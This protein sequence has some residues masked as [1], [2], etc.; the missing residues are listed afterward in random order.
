M[1]LMH[2]NIF[3]IG[4]FNNVFLLDNYMVYTHLD[5][6]LIQFYKNI[7]ENIIGKIKKN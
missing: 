2:H 1:K 7:V 6:G 3:M 4:V 5:I